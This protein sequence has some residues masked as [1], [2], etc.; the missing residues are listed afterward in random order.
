MSTIRGIIC[1]VAVTTLVGCQTT[2]S[3]YPLFS[4]PGVTRIAPPASWQDSTV[5]TSP[6]LSNQEG[7][8]DSNAPAIRDPDAFQGARLKWKPYSG[9][10]EGPSA[11]ATAAWDAPAGNTAIGSGVRTVS[12]EEELRQPPTTRRSASQ[13]RPLAGQDGWNS[14][15]EPLPESR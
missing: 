3:P 14:R 13:T 5:V 11:P 6:D 4:I 2:S 10:L 1:L 15:H 7:A 9:T 8:A 12:Y